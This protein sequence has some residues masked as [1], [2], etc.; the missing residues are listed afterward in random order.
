[1]ATS[2]H[3]IDV[4]EFFTSMPITVLAQAVEARGYENPQAE[5]SRVLTLQEVLKSS[6]EKR[7][8]MNPAK[9]EALYNRAKENYANDD[10]MQTNVDPLQMPFDMVEVDEGTWASAWVWVPNDE[11][12]KEV[13][14]LQEYQRGSYG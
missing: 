7:D 5:L 13:Q 11:L 6:F 1:M 8:N 12:E 9:A 4:A 10:Y 14:R 3:L 2:R